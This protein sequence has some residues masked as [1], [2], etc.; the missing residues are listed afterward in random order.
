[1]PVAQ[2]E[3]PEF[4]SNT[5]A[6]DVNE[7]TPADTNIG[8]PVTATDPNND[9]LIYSLDVPIDAATLST[10]MRHYGPVADQSRS[11]L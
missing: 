2:N 9:T 8:A 11:G 6:R 4:P 7:N 10:W 1:M 5:A 3:P